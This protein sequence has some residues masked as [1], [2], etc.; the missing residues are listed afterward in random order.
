MAEFFFSTSPTD[1]RDCSQMASVKTISD[2]RL[3]LMYT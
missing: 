1:Q 3:D 2:F